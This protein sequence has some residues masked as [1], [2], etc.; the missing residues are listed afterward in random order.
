MGGARGGG[1]QPPCPFFR[2]LQRVL[3]L[4]RQSKTLA[5]SPT[6]WLSFLPHQQAPPYCGANGSVVLLPTSD[7]RLLDLRPSGIQTAQRL[8]LL[9]SLLTAHCSLLT[10]HCSLLTAHCSLLSAHCSLLSALCSLLSA[11]CS[12][13]SALCS[14]LSALCSLLSALCSPPTLQNHPTY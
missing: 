2:L 9:C 6:H 11:L 5:R 13:L 4:R 8:P 12:L 10:A 7:F 1:L 3:V 14:L